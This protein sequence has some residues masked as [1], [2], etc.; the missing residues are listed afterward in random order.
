MNVQIITIKKFPNVESNSNAVCFQIPDNHVGYLWK[1]KLC[2]VSLRKENPRSRPMRGSELLK[3]RVSV[4]DAEPPLVNLFNTPGNNSGLYP[5]WVNI[6]LKNEIFNRTVY[7][8][9]W[10]AWYCY[11]NVFPSKITNCECTP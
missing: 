6:F 4:L 7:L 10:S 3:T 9:K 2:F 1:E 8:C 5:L 11:F